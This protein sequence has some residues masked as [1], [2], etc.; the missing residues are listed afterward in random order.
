MMFL[1]VMIGGGC[2]GWNFFLI[3][4]YVVIII[5]FY[6]VKKNN[7]KFVWCLWICY[8]LYYIWIC[9]DR[10][11]YEYIFVKDNLYGD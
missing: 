2:G 10:L 4:D 9:I 11:V 1:C 3:M 5:F 7:D 8:K 6:W